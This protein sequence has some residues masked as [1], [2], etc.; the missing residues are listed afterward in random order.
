MVPCNKVGFLGLIKNQTYLILYLLV[1]FQ[2]FSLVQQKL[3]LA[4]GYKS[5]VLLKTFPCEAKNNFSKSKSKAE[6]TP[7]EIF[8]KENQ[9]KK[10]FKD[11]KTNQNILIG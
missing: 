3:F 7:Q 1:H 10:I 2:R 9:I 5:L 8:V 4:S 11:K 6:K